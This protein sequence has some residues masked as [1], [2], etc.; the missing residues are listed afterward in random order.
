MRAVR[1][2]NAFPA[3]EFAVDLFEGV[4]QLDAAVELFAVGAL[5][6]FDVAVELRGAWWQDE[7]AD[8]AFLAGGLELGHE[9]GAT[10]DLNSFHGKG[11]ALHDRIQ[12]AGRG[13]SRG[14][15]MYL[16][17]LPTAEDVASSE[18]FEAETGVENDVSGIYL[19]DVTWG[20]GQVVLGLAHPVGAPEGLALDP[21][22]ATGSFDQAPALLELAQDTADH[23]GGTRPAMLVEEDG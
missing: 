22:I 4:R 8:A 5:G 3:T 17:D 11:H 23:R 10:V 21:G 7:E 9:L 6:A 15:A 2:V 14:A 19:D 13:V 1:V 16:Q 12:E 20:T 18:M